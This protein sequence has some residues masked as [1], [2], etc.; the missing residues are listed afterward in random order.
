MVTLNGMGGSWWHLFSFCLTSICQLLF[1]NIYIP[2][3]H[4]QLHMSQVLLSSFCTATVCKTIPVA[5]GGLL[6]L[7]AGCPCAGEPQAR[8]GTLAA[9][10]EVLNRKEWLFPLT[11]WLL[12]FWHPVRGWLSVQHGCVAGSYSICPPGPT[13]P[14]M[15][16]CFL[17]CLGSWGYSI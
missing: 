17:A 11:C 5:Q 10:L 16:C 15:P 2:L 13:H 4:T 6:P 8:H 7:R 12:W 3:R 14:F 9:I 1:E